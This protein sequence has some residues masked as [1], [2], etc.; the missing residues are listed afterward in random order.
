M[1]RFSRPCPRHAAYLPLF[2]FLISI[3]KCILINT[4]MKYYTYLDLDW[5]P[6]AERLKHFVLDNKD[7]L[8]YSIG[9]WRTLSLT[10]LGD[11]L[12]DLILML[13]PLNISPVAVS[14]HIVHTSEGTS[15]HRDA[16]KYNTRRILLPIM[17]CEGS[18]TRFYKSQLPTITIHQ[19]NGVSYD[20]INSNMCE[21][22]DEYCLE[23]PVA[24][25]P[26]EYH[27]VFPN[28]NNSFPRISCPIDVDKDL[29]YLFK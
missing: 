27:R 24:F 18:V 4:N 22:V 26:N 11:I 16:V 28:N 23:K 6:V 15:I 25:R 2:I 10:N 9:G 3:L 20:K 21:L 19:E 13:K 14:F 5:K 1:G 29:D 7:M 17:N 8:G 12:P